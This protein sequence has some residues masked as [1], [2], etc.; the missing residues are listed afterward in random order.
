M[1]SHSDKFVSGAWQPR[2]RQDRDAEGFEG[3]GKG[4]P[5]PSRL[6]VSGSVVSSDLIS[7]ADENEPALDESVLTVSV[8][9]ELELFLVVA[10]LVPS[11]LDAAVV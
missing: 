8:V 10:A 6:G 3:Y 7:A 11:V 5:F 9:T 4:C 2:H 1:H